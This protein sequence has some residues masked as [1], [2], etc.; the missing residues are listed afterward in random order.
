M[1]NSK[2]DVEC[3]VRDRPV[4]EIEITPAMIAAGEVVLD[5]AC[6]QAEVP[7]SWFLISAAKDVYIA[8]ENVR[9]RQVS[10]G[11]KRSSAARAQGADN[12][13]GR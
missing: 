5:R 10:S 4:D 7:A 13:N 2:Q 3:P 12:Q 1:T 9:C 11:R 6:D 8:M